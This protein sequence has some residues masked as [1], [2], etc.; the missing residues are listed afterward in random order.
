MKLKIKRLGAVLTTCA[1]LAIA[2]FAWQR[3]PAQ[4]QGLLTAVATRG[5]I[6]QTV[7]ATGTFKPSK[8]VA[9]G[10]QVSGRITHLAVRLGEEITQGSLVAEID[11]TTQ[12][13]ELKTAEASLANVKAQRQ[14]TE[15]ELANAEITLARQKN[16]YAN[17]AGAKAD[18]DSAETS[19]N[20]A[21]AQIAAFD[22]QI[23]EAEVAVETAK[24]NLGYTRI[25]APIDG[26]VLAIV[27][28]QG[29]T[30]NATQTAPTIIV[31]GQLSTMTVRAEISEADIV[32]VAPGQQVY[33]SIMG[34]P[35]VRNAACDR[36]RA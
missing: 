15:A 33:F 10:A 12:K 13:N 11:S 26:T 36:T 31:L 9:V 3:A 22:A 25:T 4:T 17:Q 34:E 21:R 5:D 27:N 1:A 19:V 23:V 2:T 35:G 32:K 18:L 14:E 7:L 16:I 20:K 29:Q 24:A 8:L 30:V 28:Q 6:E